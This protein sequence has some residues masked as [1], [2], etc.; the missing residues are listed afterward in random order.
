LTGDAAYAV[1]IRKA[2]ANAVK[3]TASFDVPFVLFI[4]YFSFSCSGN[5]GTPKPMELTIAYAVTLLYLSKFSIL[6]ETSL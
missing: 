3:T 2:G 5:T 6:N 4:F 1:C